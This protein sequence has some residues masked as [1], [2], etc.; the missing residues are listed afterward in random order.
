MNKTD[1]EA[2]INPRKGICIPCRNPPNNDS[3]KAHSA[4]ILA[5]AIS[6][7]IVK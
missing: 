6:E 4:V 1:A 7:E 2:I 3:L 5:T